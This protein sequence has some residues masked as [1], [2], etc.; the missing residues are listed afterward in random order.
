[1]GV[2]ATERARGA[3]ARMWT[4]PHIV[5]GGERRPAGA[6]RGARARVFACVSHIISALDLVHFSQRGAR[7]R[8]CERR[9][10]SRGRP[11][12]CLFTSLARILFF[13]LL[14]ATARGKAG[15]KERAHA[16][17]LRVGYAWPSSG[18]PTRT[19]T[20]LMESPVGSSDIK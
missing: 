3:A 13:S 18:K 4:S 2:R 5:P 15:K 1:M 8:R 14:F 7:R 11:E 17:R 10:G 19:R 6:P 9:N 12:L 16:A 20:S